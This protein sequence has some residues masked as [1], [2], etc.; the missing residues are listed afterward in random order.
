V[1]VGARPKHWL[2]A[3]FTPVGRDFPVFLHP[4]TN[5]EV[6]LAR[7]ERKSGRGYHGF[8]VPRRPDVTLEEDLA[9]RDLTIN[10]MAKTRPTGA[11]VDPYGGQ[12]DLQQRVLR[13]VGRRP[14]SK[15]RCACCAWRGFAAR[16]A[17]FSVAP[18]TEALMRRWWPA[19]R[20]THLVPERVWQE[21]SRGLM[22]DRP[23]RMFD[24][25]RDC[26]ALRGCCPRWTACGACRS[27]PEHHPEVDTGVH[28]MLVLAAV[29]A[30]AGAAAGA[31]ACLVH[32]LGKGTTP[33]D[34][35][36]RHIGHEQRSAVLAR[37][38]G[39]APA[40]PNDC[41]RAGRRGG[42]RA[43]QHPP[44]RRASAPARAAP[45][46]A[47]RRPA[48]PERFAEVLL[49]CECDARG[50]TG[51]EDR[52]TRKAQ[53]QAAGQRHVPLAAAEAKA[54]V[55]RQP[56]RPIAQPALQAVEQQEAS[57]K[58]ISQRISTAVCSVAGGSPAA[59]EAVAQAQPSAITLNSS[60][61]S[62][63]VT[64]FCAA[65]R[66]AQRRPLAAGRQAAVQ[67]EA[68]LRGVAQHVQAGV[69]RGQRDAGE[70]DVGGDVLGAHIGQR[71]A[72]GAVGAVAHQRAAVALRVVV[73]GFGEAVVDEEAP[74][75]C[76]S[77]PARVRMKASACGWISV[78][79]PGTK[80]ASPNTR[81]AQRGRAVGPG[82]CARHARPRHART[83][84]WPSKC[85]SCTGIASST[86]LPTTTPLKRSGRHPASAPGRR[87]APA[88]PAGAA[89]ACP[90]RSTMA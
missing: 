53:H 74:A 59:V 57:R 76:C 27:A 88:A 62:C 34:A 3:G 82:Q 45:A 17:D 13:H 14:S 84:A 52:P 4:Q 44:Q 58:T 33:P 12:R 48:P 85:S 49:A 39:R 21:L 38:A 29:R 2:A 7:T 30:A 16:F 42:A 51:F 9:R 86:S 19:A 31:L 67:Q 72:V 61:I 90:D 32:D 54:E 80:G 56:P 26:G 75:P 83:T 68:R 60:P 18:E 40:V 73:L 41:R 50:R 70:V 5:E 47:L 43:R 55:A 1:V 6:A 15:T 8:T 78:V 36:P 77:T 81:R 24:V 64:S 22:E 10:A 71:V 35:W 87:S 46:G 69:L 11:L 37:A 28:L 20:S 89:A 23:D 65:A 66:A 25:L 79:V 63:S